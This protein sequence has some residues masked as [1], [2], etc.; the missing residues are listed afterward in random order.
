MKIPTSNPTE[1]PTKAAPKSPPSP[2]SFTKIKAE[3]IVVPNPRK[4]PSAMAPIQC[5][6]TTFLTTVSGEE[7]VSFSAQ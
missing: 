1:A 2:A 7:S 3:R 5:F 6:I 4:K